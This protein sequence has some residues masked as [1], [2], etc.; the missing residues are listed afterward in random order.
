MHSLR[1]LAALPEEFRVIPGHGE[2]TTI[3]YER[4]CNPFLAGV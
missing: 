3:G 4:R 2:E 1:R